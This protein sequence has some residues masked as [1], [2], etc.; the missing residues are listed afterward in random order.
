MNREEWLAQAAAVIVKELQLEVEDFAISV[1]WPS[2]MGLS[3]VRRR[4]GECWN[5]ETSKDGV[6]Q[7]YISPVLD[8]PV[9]T[10][11]HELLHVENPE[12]KHGPAFAKRAKM[13]GFEGTP[14]STEPGKEL[15]TRLNAVIE[16]LKMGDYPHAAITPSDKKVQTTRLLKAE[17]AVHG[18]V[19][20]VTRKWLKDMGAPLCPCGQEMKHEELEEE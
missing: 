16:K 5:G 12:S 9:P 4:V 14:T 20:R 11:A 10:I 13:L 3:K 2:K 18:Y 15:E 1:G 7:V 17:C 6:P 19:V 8:D